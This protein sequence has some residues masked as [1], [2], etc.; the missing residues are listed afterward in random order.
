MTE[1]LNRAAQLLE[2]AQA[3][4][5]AGSEGEWTM[6][7]GP[8][9]G[10]QMM[11]GAGEDPRVLAVSRGAQTVLRV[12]R[13]AGAVRVE[14][15]NHGGCCVLESRSVGQCVERVVADQRLYAAACTG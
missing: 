10:W 7:Q 2:T 12:L 5:A 4:S 11:C 8:D 9:G 6:L 3:C 15:W 1:L 14:A 13:R